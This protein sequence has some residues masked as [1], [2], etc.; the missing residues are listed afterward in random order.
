M[1]DSFKKSK[2]LICKYPQTTFAEAMI[3]NIPT[4]LVF[5]KK[6]WHFDSNFLKVIEELKNSK[7]I[8]E[9]IQ[10]ATDHINYYWENLDE[11]WLSKKTFKARED[12]FDMCCK[13]S[14]NW[15]EDWKNF[16]IS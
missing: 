8:F 14:N 6:Y 7:I 1:L 13:Y 16:L 15:L 2:M 5:N 12:F 10:N 3:S 11:W 9:E 4:I